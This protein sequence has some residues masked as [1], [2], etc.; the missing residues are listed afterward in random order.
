MGVRLVVHNFLIDEM[1]FTGTHNHDETIHRD[2]VDQHPIYAISGL[3]EILNT[4]ETS[5]INISNLIR[6]KDIDLNNK[7]DT[8]KVL[9]ENYT[10]SKVLAES[11]II[12]NRI[13]ELNTVDNV[14]DTGTIDLSYN[15]TTNTLSATL[16]IYEDPNDTNL[17]VSSSNGL[18]APKTEMLESDTVKWSRETDATTYTLTN[19]YSNCL[20]FS[21]YNNINNNN[22][23][24][25]IA[26]YW[27]LYN[28][29]SIRYTRDY[30]YYTDYVYSGLVSGDFYD[31]YKFITEFR[32]Y[33]TDPYR[34]FYEY[35]VHPIGIIIGHVFDE[36]G[37]PHTLSAVISRNKSYTASDFGFAIIYNYRLPGE[38]I[39]AD[40][41]LN[42]ITSDSWRTDYHYNIYV[43]K[44]ENRVT[45][46]CTSLRN[47]A[48]VSSLDDAETLSYEHTF[49]IDLDD[50][51]WG[52]Y[53]RRKVRYGYSSFSQGYVE[54]LNTYFHSNDMYSVKNRS[55]SVKIDPST[56]N[57]VTKN[58]NGLFVQKFNISP[59]ANN[60]LTQK[61]NGYFVQNAMMIS[62]KRLN[63]LEQPSTN[64]FY[65]HKS[66][67]FI[68]ITQTSHGFSLGDFIYYDNRT[69]KYQKAL[70]IDDWDINIVGMVSY[71]Y[72]ADKFEYVC[73]GYVPIT[74]FTTAHGYI[75]GMPLYISDTTPG[76]V[77][78]EQPDISKAVGYPVGNQG[79]IISIERG[80]Q[81]YTYGNIGDF[82]IS[83]NTYNV[84]SDGYIKVME[85]IEYKVSLVNNMLLLLDEDFKNKYII[86]NDE[87]NTISFKNTE[88]LYINNN[89]SPGMNLFIK[90]F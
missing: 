14:E 18:Y 43:K 89:V 16:N 47:T 9:S 30:R 63:G 75:Q 6:E 27:T 65:V 69:D 83:A 32:Q 12:N 1:D 88:E 71:L 59:D 53:F 29:N 10:D 20:R 7:I 44:Y 41:N 55:A 67:S 85:G 37:N 11:L 39:I 80:M 35:K 42:N 23:N 58:T 15:T 48:V 31:N 21:H 46:S 17:I 90:G 26:N 51:H 86:M 38:E 77:T 60:A 24:P 49:N 81:Y 45:V 79:V 70:A 52:H 19:F 34:P 73:S 4:I 33:Y 8:N 74:E 61:S 28:N 62:S 78:Q 84:R 2:W 54:F 72:S 3:Q 68:D 82:K 76:K 50:Y 40:Y 56:E 66:H 25:A 5:I 87:N 57:A 13:D 36:Y 22:Y 64:Y